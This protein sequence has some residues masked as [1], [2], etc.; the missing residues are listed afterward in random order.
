MNLHRRYIVYGI[1]VDSEFPLT[2]VA[3]VSVGHARADIRLELATAA[4]FR[5]V[6]R[7]LPPSIDDWIQ[8]FVLA[9]GGVYI[10]VRDILETVVSA[11][12]RQAS[13]AWADGA[14]RTAFEANFLNFVLSTALTL[15]GEEPFH[16]TVLDLGG[17]VVGLLGP[18]GAG[19]S[20]LAACL[21]GR[22]ADLVTDDM[23]RLQLEG[24]RALVHAGPYRLKLHRDSAERFLPKAA[25]QGYFNVVTE[26]LLIQPR[27]SMPAY[28]VPRELAALF[29]LGD[30]S[31]AGPPKGD[32][33]VSRMNGLALA[34]AL[35][36]SAMNIRYQAPDRLERRLRFAELVARTLPVYA[37]E[38]PRDFA[39]MDRVAEEIGRVVSV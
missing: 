29:W 26:K 16:S 36:A 31:D 17:R 1:V 14:D 33:R 23:L 12:G 6:S 9:D 34:R 19:K 15:Q 35:I 4:S 10:R 18:S 39:I 20:T 28:D 13:C 5:A 3:E 7:D 38:Y 32:V 30:A 11:D 27:D 21:I 2:T 25:R 22:G 24:Q 8:Y 37:L